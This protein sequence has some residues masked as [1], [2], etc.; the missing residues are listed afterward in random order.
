L[1]T[2]AVVKALIWIV[3]AACGTTIVFQSLGL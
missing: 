1:T 2:A 3:F